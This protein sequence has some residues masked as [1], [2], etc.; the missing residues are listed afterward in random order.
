MLTASPAQK[1]STLSPTDVL[2]KRINSLLRQRIDLQKQGNKEA[3]KQI[4]RDLST[5]LAFISGKQIDGKAIDKKDIASL[6]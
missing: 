2:T 3:E 4:L 5:Q 1:M 6:S